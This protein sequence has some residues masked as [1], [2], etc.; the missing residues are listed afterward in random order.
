M[1]VG[2]YWESAKI[3]FNNN[4]M[5]KADFLANSLFIGLIIFIF[6]NLW[7][8]VYSTGSG[9]IE[10]FTINMMIWYFLLTESIVTS[11]GKVIEA[12]G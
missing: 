12:F 9:A 8:V 3:S 5:Y 1:G 10:G 4:L 2:K 11:P 7:K 6:I